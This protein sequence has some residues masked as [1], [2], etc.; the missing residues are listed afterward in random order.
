M[1]HVSVRPSTFHSQC[2]RPAR[3]PTQRKERTPYNFFEA[4]FVE[5]VV[6]KLL[7]NP[8]QKASA[9]EGK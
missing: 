8:T 6:L 5:R 1:E 7:R 4:V 9:T 3:L 2:G